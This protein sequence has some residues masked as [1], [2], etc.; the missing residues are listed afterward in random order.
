MTCYKPGKRPLGFN[1]LLLCDEQPPAIVDV[2]V[3]V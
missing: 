2:F 3:L 1:F